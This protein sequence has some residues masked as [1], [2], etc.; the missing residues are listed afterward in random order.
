MQATEA[1]ELAREV[2]PSPYTE[3]ERDFVLAVTRFE[4]RWGAGWKGAGAGSHNWGAVVEFT[5]GQG[6][7]Q[8][9]RYYRQYPTDADGLRDAGRT[10]LKGNV[11][12]AVAAGDG[13]AAVAAMKENRYFEAPLAL[14]ASKVAENY[15]ALL[16]ETGRA[17][18]LSFQG[19]FPWLLA[20]AA[21]VGAFVAWR[22]W[23]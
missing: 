20:S 4:T 13:A 3:P 8:T 1:L 6:F 11:R 21:A 2:L 19:G 14:Y 22:A 5:P 15:A 18:L 10:I 12:R 9:D 16:K 17:R 7:F 23:G